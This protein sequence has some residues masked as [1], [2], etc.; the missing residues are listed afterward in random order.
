MTRPPTEAALLVLSR[1]PVNNPASQTTENI[2]RGVVKSLRQATS[3]GELAAPKPR[4]ISRTRVPTSVRPQPTHRRALVRSLRRPSQF[5]AHAIF[6]IEPE[7][8]TV[9]IELGQE[10]RN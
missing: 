4:R 5:L 8:R 7:I 2:E 6:S 9:R 3:A 1:D 10:V